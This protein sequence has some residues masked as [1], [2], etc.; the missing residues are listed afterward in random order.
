MCIVVCILVMFGIVDL[1]CQEDEEAEADSCESGLSS[2]VAADL[3]RPSVTGLSVTSV[4]LS[5]CLFMV[6][7][8]VSVGMWFKTY[9]ICLLTEVSVVY[10]IIYHNM[11]PV[12]PV[13]SWERCRISP[14]CLL[15]KCCKRQ[16]NQYCFIWL[17]FALF[18]F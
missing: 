11:V 5:I 16:L 18:A 3:Q 8:N 12:M 4:C 14:P 15:A 9:A 10:L 1:L 17:Y 7:D 2:N 6:C 13:S